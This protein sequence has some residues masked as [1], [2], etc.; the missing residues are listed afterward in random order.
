MLLCF[1]C[2]GIIL[3]K[4]HVRYIGH[5]IRVYQ[6]PEPSNILFQNL[7]FLDSARQCRKLTTFV[8]T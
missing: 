1:M 6:A 4:N 5:R 2:F 3:Q 8:I 7:K